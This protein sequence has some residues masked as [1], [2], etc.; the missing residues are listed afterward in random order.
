MQTTDIHTVDI[1]DRKIWWMLSE[2]WWDTRKN[3]KR[4]IIFFSLSFYVKGDGEDT[5]GQPG[6]RQTTSPRAPYKN[7]SNKNFLFLF[8]GAFHKYMQG[9]SSVTDRFNYFYICCSLLRTY[10][11]NN[12]KNTY[13][14]TSFL[15]AERH[16]LLA[17]HLALRWQLTRNFS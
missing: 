3:R 16:L 17:T 11:G 2:C 9:V 10:N 12:N 4:R 6:R 15:I 5:R 7:Y 14:K 8:I 1:I 13:T